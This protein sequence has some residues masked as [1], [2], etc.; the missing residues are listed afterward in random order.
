[1]LVH[2]RHESVLAMHFIKILFKSEKEGDLSRLDAQ[3][4]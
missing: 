3:Q 2:C 1:M 4:I